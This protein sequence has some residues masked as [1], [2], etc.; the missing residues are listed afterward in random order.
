MSL[1]QGDQW[2]RRGLCIAAAAVSGVCALSPVYAA[3]VL[4]DATK[5]EMAG[6]A[7]WVIDAD[8]WNQNM[9]A[10]PCSGSTNE[11]N[12]SR[13]PTPSQAGITSTTSETYWTGGISAWAV[14]LVKA[15]HTVESLPAGARISF[16]DATN[17]QDLSN[18]QLF[19]VV[20]PQGP[21]SAVEKQAILDFVAAGGGLFM[22]GDHETS[23]RD[24]DGWDAPH[25]WNDLSGATSATSAGLFGIWMRVDGVDLQGSEDWFDDGVDS[26]TETD[27]ADPIIRGP[28][29]VGSGGL[30]LFGST[31]MELNPLDNATVK[32]HVWRT[33][34]AHDNSRVTFATAR[35]GLGRV[36]AIGDSSPA[37]DDTGD[38]SDSLHPGWD[39]A[40]GGVKNRE[41]HLNA[42]HWLLN[43]APDVT[44]PVI[45]AGPAAAPF[46]CSASITWTTDEA[47]SSVVDYGTSASYGNTANAAGFV[48][49]H[50][51]LLS[52]LTPTTSYHYRVSSTDQS[53]NGPTQ[54]SDDLFST[55]TAAPP[56]IVAGPLVADITGTGATI[57]WTTDEIASSE[58]QYGTTSSY[59]VSA[60][61]GGLATLH[62]VPLSGLT[63]DT[64]YHYRTVSTDGCGHGPTYSIDL[65]FTTGPAS[66]DL[67][68][69]ALKQYTSAQ[70][71][72]LPLGTTIPAGGYLVVVR[73]S[74]RAAF[75]TTFPAMPAETV[76]L[77][78]NENGSCGTQGCFPQINGDETFELYDASNVLVDGPT[79]AMS[80]THR[81]LQRVAPGSPAGSVASWNSVDE[82]AANPGAGAGAQSGAGVR[83]N[84][85]SDAAN[86]AQEFVEIYYDPGNAPPDS[87]PPAT[88]TDLIAQPSS[89]TA[90][91]LSWTAVGDD[92]T[93]GTA[94]SYDIRQSNTRI[95]SES[96]FA[97]ATPLSGEPTPRV[98]GSSEQFTAS[99]LSNNTTYYFALKVRDE[100]A[101][102]SGLSNDTWGTTGLPGSGSPLDHLVISQLRIAG[103]SDDVIELYNPTDLSV[104]LTGYSVQYLAANGNFGF[105][106]NLTAANSVPSHGWYL[107]AANGYSGTPSR[108]DS[109]G[110]SNLSG[111]A[112]HALLVNKTSN[113]S[114]CS[115]PAIKDKVGYGASATCPEG[116]SGKQTASPGTGLSVSRKPGGALGAGQDSDI[117]SDDFL[118]PATPLFHNRFD[119][120]ASPPSG[121]GN[122]GNS[123]F[124]LQS[125]SGTTLTWGRA[126]SAIGYRV[127]RG[128]TPDFM[129]G[130]P[131]PWQSPTTNTVVDVTSPAPV[132]YY[133]VRA[134][135]GTSESSD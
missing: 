116:G 1:R 61:V 35:Y 60:S 16:G 52:P 128:T 43:P 32:A 66:I 49:S 65:T 134:T 117:N 46:D 27:P 79:I 131:P 23:D 64:T 47:A 84:E 104:S 41:I 124:L 70:S 129:T 120:P 103:T 69:W 86:F 73:D 63:P 98:S 30:G 34:Q 5:H 58:V 12:P 25:V 126:S 26:N 6:N 76:Y 108:D 56:A 91:R 3:A 135:D 93:T 20:E 31:S 125:V 118:P 13:L 9:P 123:L 29:G 88:V 113:V 121:L 95:R 81:A 97:A 133:L 33:G 51:V 110:T 67:S 87:I 4:F 8:A 85:F 102:S 48:Q 105:R 36:A 99:G 19:I 54:S 122:V 39:K 14:D 72:T 53:G 28:F 106:V 57:R 89:A 18:Y 101:N 15:G 119:T 50:T 94:A 80:P 2:L 111:T 107:V 96:D 44:P 17:P 40:T 132:Y 90:I 74:T 75:T 55:A 92:G 24:C 42:C 115:D 77:D 114:G 22:V 7:D 130:S 45:T 71:F 78:S 11:A 127:Y 109:L 112:G 59:G 100:A 82:S 21:F 10:Y 38:P 68:G 37:D 83:I 62:T